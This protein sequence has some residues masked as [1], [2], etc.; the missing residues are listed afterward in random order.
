MIEKYIYLQWS[1]LTEIEVAGIDK[2]KDYP[3]LVDSYVRNCLVDGREA[4][5]EELKYINSE[6]PLVSQEEALKNYLDY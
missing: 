4:T 3:D 6:M 5:K 2:N 1:K